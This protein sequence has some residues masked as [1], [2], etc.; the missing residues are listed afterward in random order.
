MFL[1]FLLREDHHQ[2]EPSC[3][4]LRNSHTDC[5]AVSFRCIYRQ[6]DYA[7]ECNVMSVL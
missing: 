1:M 2:H 6:Y 3:S 5:L 7:Y 4:V